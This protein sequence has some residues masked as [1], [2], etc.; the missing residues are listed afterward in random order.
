MGRVRQLNFRRHRPAAA[1]QPSVWHCQRRGSHGM[2]APPALLP[3]GFIACAAPRQ[4]QPSGET[5]SKH[6]QKCVQ[7]LAAEEATAGPSRK[8]R[9]RASPP[10]ACAQGSAGVGAPL[11]W[12]TILLRACPAGMLCA[13]AGPQLREH[14]GSSGGAQAAP[15]EP[16]VL[17]E[18][19]ARPRH[20][21]PTASP[22]GQ[23]QDPEPG[24]SLAR[25]LTH[26]LCIHFTYPPSVVQNK[27]QFLHLC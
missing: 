11:S 16:S 18:G 7:G 20:P 4:Q 26:V 6:F 10:A 24:R 23:G 1:A 5:V 8:R 19:K 14:G 9:A 25:S 22:V 3:L 21:G 15:L 12:G 17:Q 13:G 27:L 2:R